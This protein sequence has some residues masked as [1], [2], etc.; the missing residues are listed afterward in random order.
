MGSSGASLLI[1]RSLLCRWESQEE[2]PLLAYPL[3][4]LSNFPTALH[5]AVAASPNS[6]WVRRLFVDR[7][8]PSA[9]IVQDIERL[10][11]AQSERGWTL[12]RLRE[13]TL[14]ALAMSTNH[15]DPSLQQSSPSSTPDGN[16]AFG[17]L[18]RLHLYF[19][20]MDPLLVGILSDFP[21]LTHL[22][23]TRPFSENLS[24]AV[25]RLLGGETGRS[26]VVCLIVEAGIY[27]D[28]RTLVKLRE[29]QSSPLGK[30]RLRFIDNLMFQHGPYKPPEI[31]TL[32]GS[33]ERSSSSH[34]INW[35]TSSEERGFSYFAQRATGS[36][37]VWSVR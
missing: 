15:L 21:R 32:A 20:K 36:E 33:D 34:V 2:K 30:G 25:F 26:Q 19:A 35:V 31:E 11:C 8:T 9:D 27:M 18:T 23:L 13:V 10:Q 4:L 24:G 29:L 1:T 28:Q 7:Q 12:P 5:A 14:S 3:M 22:R 37:G 17:Q 6:Q 16:D